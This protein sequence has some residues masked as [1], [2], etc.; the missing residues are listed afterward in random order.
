M[1][2]VYLR[3]PDGFSTGQ[4]TCADGPCAASCHM[5]WCISPWELPICKCTVM[6]AAL[7][8]IEV[9]PQLTGLWGSRTW[10]CRRLLLAVCCAAGLV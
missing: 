2:N 4:H 10:V 9:C 1:P 8:G 7:R 6:A 5:M 3:C